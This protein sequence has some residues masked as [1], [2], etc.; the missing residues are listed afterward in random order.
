MISLLL[1][2]NDSKETKKYLK[3]I[4]DEKN[5]FIEIIPEKKEYSLS[6]IKN[7]RRET[8]I[9]NR[10]IRIYLLQNFHL[11]SLEAQNSFLKLLEEPPKNVLFILTADN[12]EKLIPTIRSRTKIIYINKKTTL[13]LNPKIKEFLEEF[14]K[15]ANFKFPEKQITLDEIIIFFHERLKTDKKATL[16]IKEALRLK[17]LLENNNLNEQLTIDH[18]LIFIKKQ[19][20]MK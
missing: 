1:I 11:S 7:L 6:E 10:L 19:Y 20:T 9:Y 18:I 15:S 16:I 14:I 5:I 17:S 2:S 8:S 13:K 4:I 3:K 12:E